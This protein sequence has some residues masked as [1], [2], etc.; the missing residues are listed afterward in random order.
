MS[1]KKGDVEDMVEQLSLFREVYISED[2]G[3]E[4]L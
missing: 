4:Y 1:S 3:Q 2:Y